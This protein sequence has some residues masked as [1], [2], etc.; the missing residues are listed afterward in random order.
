MATYLLVGA[1][2]EKAASLHPGGVL[3][4]SIGLLDYARR[5]GHAVEIVNTARSGFAQQRTGAMIWSGLMRVR[6]VIRALRT[7]RLAGVFIFAGAGI[8]F[9]ERSLM[10]LA[11]RLFG[12][13]DVFV[14]V[15][16]WFFSVRKAHPL[17]RALVRALLRVPHRLAATGER[18]SELFT[19]LGVA[20]HRQVRIHYWLRADYPVATAPKPA[21]TGRPLRMLFLGWMIREKGVGEIM[22]ALARLLPVYQLTFTFVGGGTLLDE[23]RAAIR[24]NGWSER[25]QAPGWVSDADLHAALAAADVFVLPSYAEGFP[26][27]LIEAFSF[28]TPSIVSDV[29]GVSETLQDGVNGLLITPRSVDSLCEAMRRYLDDPAL[30]A[31]HSRAALAAVR[32][33][34]DPDTNCRILFDATMSRDDRVR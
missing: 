27:S 11:C 7:R 18:W 6:D 2:P 29:G 13:P 32:R 23:V 30:V 34:H 25:V 17:R 15:D 12:V 14:I 1:D 5:H 20:P 28:A 21:P 3:T 24:D 26:M 4:L 31:E 33:N 19:D 9:Y 16:G 8:G 22:D 10:S